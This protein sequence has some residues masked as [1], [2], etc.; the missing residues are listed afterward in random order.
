MSR[1]VR[2][3]SASPYRQDYLSKISDYH[4]S[5]QNPDI[6]DRMY[7]RATPTAR[8]R[9]GGMARTTNQTELN[10]PICHT[11][12]P[13][14]PDVMGFQDGSPSDV[15]SPNQIS[16]LRRMLNARKVQTNSPQSVVELA[17]RGGK[18]LRAGQGM[19]LLRKRG[20]TPGVL[21]IGGGRLR[22]RQELGEG[23]GWEEEPTGKKTRQ[24][25]CD[26]EVVLEALRQHKRLGGG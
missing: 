26:K 20:R 18:G 3:E 24:D 19:G 11:P 13:R 5:R 17:M 25:P 14:Q 2:A 10:S 23:S 8:V 15:D 9:V 12:K 21:T 7:A 4:M 1:N 22:S 16:L 6:L